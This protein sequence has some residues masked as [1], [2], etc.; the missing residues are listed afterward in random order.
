MAPK[1]NDLKRASLAT[2]RFR[3]WNNSL[4]GELVGVCFKAIQVY[5]SRPRRQA[6]YDGRAKDAR[7]DSQRG[8]DV[9]QAHLLEH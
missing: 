5:T 7:S 3:S 9:R 1:E 2:S 8:A 6:L 4:A